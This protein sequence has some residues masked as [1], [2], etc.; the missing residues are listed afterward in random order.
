MSR[1]GLMSSAMLALA[2]GVASA[3]GGSFSGYAPERRSGPKPKGGAGSERAAV[4]LKQ[5][6]KANKSIPDRPIYSRQVA[7]AERRKVFKGVRHSKK[8]N[9]MKQNLPGGAAAVL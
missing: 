1:I 6:L 2:A 4:R 9:A 8:L 7:R 3:F 5:K